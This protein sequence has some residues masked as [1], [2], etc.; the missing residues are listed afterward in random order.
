MHQNPRQIDKASGS[1]H[2][3]KDAPYPA[4]PSAR[5]G[6]ERCFF[7]SPSP[8]TERAARP[9]LNDA[10]SG[11][12]AAGV[13]PSTWIRKGPVPLDQV[14]PLSVETAKSGRALFNVLV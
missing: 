10:G 9:M 11:T 1:K 3:N 7:Q 6:A 8:T 13:V 2:G 12:A 14:L 5:C 4:L